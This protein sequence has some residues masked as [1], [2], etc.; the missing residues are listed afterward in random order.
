MHCSALPK[1]NGASADVTRDAVG[2]VVTF[3]CETGKLFTTGNKIWSTVCGLGM[4]W[5]EIP[6]TCQSRLI[7]ASYNLNMKFS[8][9][10]HKQSS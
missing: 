10:P 7:T 5:S 8:P 3:T 4:Q 2:T 9:P 6:S 1:V